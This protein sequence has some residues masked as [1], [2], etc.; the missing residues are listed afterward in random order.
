M[1]SDR[2]NYLG[3]FLYPSVQ[4]ECARK[5]SPYCHLIGT[6]G[7]TRERREEKIFHLDDGQ[8]ISSL[9]HTG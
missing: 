9:I 1:V 5:I 3:W 7:K 2:S 6:T 4:K 8:H